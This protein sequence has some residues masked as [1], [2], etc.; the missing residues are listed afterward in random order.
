VAAPTVTLIGI[1]LSRTAQK[2]VV[3]GDFTLTVTYIPDNATEQGVTWKSSNSGVATVSEGKVTAVGTGTATI[4]AT[5]TA[6]SKIT[7]TCEVTVA[8]PTVTPTGISIPSTFTLGVGSTSFLTVT[9]IPANTTEQDITWG[10]SNSGVATVSNGIVTAV[11][12]G[13]ATI[14]AT[15]TADSK[16]TATCTVTVQ[17]SYTGAGVNIVFS[18]PED[19]IITLE[20]TVDAKDAVVITAPAGYSRYLWYVDIWQLVVTDVPTFTWPPYDNGPGPHQV[21]VIVEKTDGSHFS[22]T[23]TYTVG[24]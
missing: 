3:G 4:T 5:S 13:T 11:A 23:L 10:S 22:K 14:T 18:G 7:A 1:S 19:E 20:K 24:Y 12:T 17:A 16:I 21:T 2:L 9:Y 8:E 6:D 15:S